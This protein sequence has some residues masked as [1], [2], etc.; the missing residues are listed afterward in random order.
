[1]AASCLG[2]LGGHVLDRDRG[3]D[4]AVLVAFGL[5]LRVLATVCLRGFPRE[6]P[7]VRRVVQP[8]RYAVVLLSVRRR[9]LARHWH[10]RL[11]R[12]RSEWSCAAAPP[13]S[14]MNSHVEHGASSPHTLSQ[15]A[16]QWPVGHWGRP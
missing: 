5:E 4:H 1:L 3:L 7:L 14:V 12:A 16:T 13:S 10:C 11:L 9:L 6:L 15:P 2:C 8:A